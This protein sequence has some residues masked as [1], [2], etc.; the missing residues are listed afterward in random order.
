MVK[1]LNR[2]KNLTERRRQGSGSEGKAAVDKLE[3]KGE[4]RNRRRKGMKKEIKSKLE[5]PH[6]T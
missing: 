6:S 4:L 1:R 2:K 3:M 5:K